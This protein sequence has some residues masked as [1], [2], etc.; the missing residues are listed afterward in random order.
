MSVSVAPIEKSQTQALDDLTATPKV[1]ELEAPTP[2]GV[3]FLKTG[4]SMTRV[5]QLMAKL[6]SSDSVVQ[7]L[8]KSSAFTND[9]MEYRN[10]ARVIAFNHGPSFP[11]GASSGA[12]ANTL[13]PFVNAFFNRER[14]NAGE[15]VM[16]ELGADRI[17][18][19]GSV[20]G[21]TVQASNWDVVAR[22]LTSTATVD[23]AGAGQVVGNGAF[24]SAQP[25]GINLPRGT[26]PAGP[27]GSVG[28]GATN[29]GAGFSMKDG[30]AGG[31]VATASLQ[32]L[33]ATP[34][35]LYRYAPPSGS[36]ALEAINAY[37][38]SRAY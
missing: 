21:D 24:V 34:E 6:G 11:M 27:M 32:Q 9:A 33:K 10:Q 26:N 38:F 22:L 36:G 23:P 14:L 3:P 30:A 12:G 5:Q 28:M 16:P 29:S 17:R 31:A 7:Q 20:F 37:A 13:Q 8:A 25:E 19:T 2:S 1:A 35:P 4:T 18:A 15:R